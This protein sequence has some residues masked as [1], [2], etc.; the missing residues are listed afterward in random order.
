MGI[1]YIENEK[2]LAQTI[3]IALKNIKV[4]D[5][6]THLFPPTYKE[7][8][9]FGID[10][11]LTYHYLIA[12]AMRQTSIAYEHF[13]S[14]NKKEQAALIWDTL[15]V[16]NSPLS[17]AT[18]GVITILE[19][20]G[21][22]YA[23]RDLDDIRRQ[24]DA[25]L[26]QGNYIDKVF[27]LANVDKVVMTNDPF[28][29]GEREYMGSAAADNRFLHS[30]RLDALTSNWTHVGEQLRA[31]G[32]DIETELSEKTVK[33]LTRFLSDWISRLNPVY[34]AISL[35]PSFKFPDDSQAAMLLQKVILPVCS[36]YGLPLAIMLGAR[37]NVNPGL[38][39]AGDAVGTASIEAV[40]NLCAA[41]P[42][43][44]FLVTVLARENQYELTVMARKF[45]NMMLFGCWWYLNTPY[46]VDEL[47]RMRFELLGT[48]FIPQHS[49]C[50]VLEQLIYKW[51]HS[52]KI[53]EKVLFDK[54]SS[55]LNKG[56][57]LTQQDV[58]R[59]IDKL[60]RENFLTFSAKPGESGCRG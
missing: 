3:E 7:L 47:T 16:N 24:F 43:N 42:D 13:W 18:Q 9:L 39:L 49:D 15:F 1:K 33:E 31:L 17:E 45:R 46:F 56:W 37:R 11:I 41:Y 40:A 21:V 59:D 57:R 54:Y 55:V 26:G 36:D 38:R 20:L 5:M 22:D 30:L 6:H 14:L 23:G 53:I 10:E 19:A 12:E 50:R 60:F 8:C 58:K 28:N 32:Y 44:R 27:V 52:F 35:P 48:S 2:Q 34:L 51:Q 4:I 29:P 25:L